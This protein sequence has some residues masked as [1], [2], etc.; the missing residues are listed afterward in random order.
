M[1]VEKPLAIDQQGLEEVENA[2]RDTKSLANNAVPQL[3]VDTID[4]TRLKFLKLRDY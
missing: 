3:C 2:L 1:F 4:V